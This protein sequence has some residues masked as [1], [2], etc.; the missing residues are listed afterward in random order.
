VANPTLTDLITRVRV[1]ARDNS[2]VST[3]NS[4]TDANIIGW[5]NIGMRMVQRRYAPRLAGQTSAQT[6]LSFTASTVA[7]TTLATNYAR[8]VTLMRGASTII[9]GP[10]LVWKDVDEFMN[11]R[12]GQSKTNVVS[13]S[14]LVDSLYPVYWTGWREGTT[15][16]ADQGKW[17]ILIHPTPTGTV[18][19]SAIV[20]LEQADMSNG[21]DS[22][23]VPAEGCSLIECIASYFAAK[24]LGRPW[25]DA[26]M[27]AYPELKE[28]VAWKASDE[29]RNQGPRAKGRA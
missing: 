7:D 20:E 24:N 22:P 12:G 11:L 21:T 27:A 6:G 28:E 3:N 18:T 10:P 16:A 26:F 14:G 2:S 23:D 5:L 25:A 13:G 4:L 17:T 8:I 9:Y 15:T 1:N 19:L 29:L